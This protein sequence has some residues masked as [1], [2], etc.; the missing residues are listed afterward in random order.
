MSSSYRPQAIDTSIVADRLR[1]ELLRQRSS[2]TRLEMAAALNR[3]TRELSICSLQQRFPELSPAAFARK[4]I[5]VWF[6]EHQW[7]EFIPG[8]NVTQWIQDSLAL[9]V[10]LH[11]IF[12]E[13]K[14][15]YYITGGV[16]ATAY[17]EP[18][19]TQ[20]L[21]VVLNMIPEGLQQ[22]VQSLE[23]AGF[24]VPGVEDAVTGRTQTLQIIHQ[25][26]VM[27]ADLMLSGSDEFDIVK[28]QRRQLLSIPDRGVLYFAS[29]EDVIL[30]KLQWRRFSQSEK[31]WRD[32]LGILKT[33]TDKLDR[34]YLETWAMRLDF[35]SDLE[36]AFQA[37]GL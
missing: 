36:Q 6:G 32:I 15:D 25:Q 24:Y 34:A 31:Q 5:Q 35:A 37:A 11:L 18:R 2:Q 22:L 27:Q 29:P 10:Q 30:S 19:T 26:T 8:E 1:F 12:A 13:L 33:Q 14:V 7:T 17:G 3:S 21:D 9:A 28:L 23:L 16:A 4:V 20:D